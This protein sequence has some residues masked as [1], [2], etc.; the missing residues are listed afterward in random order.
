M[1]AT[2]SMCTAKPQLSQQIFSSGYDAKDIMSTPLPGPPFGS[3][4]N[5]QPAPHQPSIKTVVNTANLG[6]FPESFE[7][8]FRSMDEYNAA[9]N[10][11]LPFAWAP[12]SH[13][14]NNKPTPQQPSLNEAN[15]APG[16][17]VSLPIGLELGPIAD[18]LTVVSQGDEGSP[19]L[20]PQYPPVYTLGYALQDAPH[21]TGATDAKGDHFDVD[22]PDIRTADASHGALLDDHE[23]R[24]ANGVKSAPAPPDTN[25]H[26]LITQD[27]HEPPPLTPPQSNGSPAQG[28][29]NMLTEGGVPWYLKDFDPVG[30]TAVSSSK[31]AKVPIVRSGHS[32]DHEDGRTTMTGDV[33][34]GK[35][36]Q[37]GKHG[38]QPVRVLKR[39]DCDTTEFDMAHVEKEFIKAFRDFHSALSG[40]ALNNRSA[41][42][43]I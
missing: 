13:V 11:P 29:N 10:D 37:P 41:D 18:E 36:V 3:M 1:P 5:K 31:T 6:G 15:Y 43:S 17:G 14:G 23:Q 42:S 20:Q 39:V 28:T 32:P 16:S 34:E 19:T 9:G 21:V 40:A 24:L 33:S 38:N 2:W 27:S 7:S 35:I 22:G 26:I 25:G 8:L 4:G 12:S 30:T